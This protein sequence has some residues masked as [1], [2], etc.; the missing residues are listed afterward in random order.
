M[1]YENI[2]P[3][4]SFRI[5]QLYNPSGYTPLKEKKRYRRGRSTPYIHISG[6]RGD[7]LNIDTLNLDN[8]IPMQNLPRRSRRSRKLLYPIHNS[9]Y[10]KFGIPPIIP[11]KVLPFIDNNPIKYESRKVSPKWYK[12]NKGTKRR[13][14]IDDEDIDQWISFVTPTPTKGPYPKLIDKFI[15]RSKQKSKK[16]KRN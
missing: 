2:P 7:R 13:D 10:N 5:K 15:G 14:L 8:Y 11:Y 12:N 1:T 3:H 6:K 16:R 9:Y 4:L